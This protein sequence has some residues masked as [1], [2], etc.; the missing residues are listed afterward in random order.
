MQRLHPV[1]VEYTYHIGSRIDLEWDLPPLLDEEDLDEILEAL[2]SPPEY[3]ERIAPM[4]FYVGTEEVTGKNPSEAY[5]KFFRHYQRML[6]TIA[7][8]SRDACRNKFH[9]RGSTSFLGL[10]LCPE[11]I[12]RLIE[13]DYENADNTYSRIVSLVKSGDICPVVTAPFHIL[14]PSLENFEIRLL[15]RIGLTIYWPLLKAYHRA[16]FRKLQEEIF[17]VVFWLPEG[18]FSRNVL[19]IL[20]TEFSKKC[21]ES[22]IQERHLALL[23]DTEQVRE[24]ENDSLMKR[25]HAIRPTNS[26][27]DQVS[28]LFRDRAFTQWVTQGHPSVK[29]MLDR[30]IAKVD[31]SLRESGI[32]YLW[33]HMEPIESLVNTH[34]AA[35]NFQ[36]KLIKLTELGYQI[37]SPDTFVRRKLM[38]KY[39]HADNEPLRCAPL[40]NTGW[41]GWE[42]APTSLLRWEGIQRDYEGHPLH[43]D[44]DRPYRRRD[45]QSEPVEERGPQC[46]KPALWSTFRTCHKA[47]V[48]ECRTFLGGM[49]ELLRKIVPIERIPAQRRNVEDFL[50]RCSLIYWREH[51]IQTSSCSEADVQLI[52]FVQECLTKDCPEDAI[53]EEQACIAGVAA[54]AIFFSFEAQRSVTFSVEHIDHRATYEAVMLMTY[55]IIHAAQAFCWAD[56]RE[57]AEAL[58]QIMKRELFEF[59]S[60]Y[61]RYELS[62]LGVSLEDWKMSIVS[63]VEDSDLNVVARASRRIAARSLRRLGFGSYI[64]DPSDK[65]ISMAIGHLWSQEIDQPNLHWKNVVFCGLAEE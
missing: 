58:I 60:A 53:T 57:E 37:L 43:V 33:T 42:D 65:N 29:K 36:Q 35:M 64:V 40:D 15:V 16:V 1:Q 39:A 20:H 56:Q 26:T 27:R 38:K 52:E 46:W 47:V 23:L 13:F 22:G 55:A 14:L 25:W 49:L 31:A 61:Y 44:H 4:S 45:E 5:A 6:H 28:L 19:E 3:H 7:G 11:T 12:R 10:G 30:T 51:F 59:E 9:E 2:S 8:V 17:T 21:E 48:G 18:G 41:N 63:Q 34:K 24:R 62:S 32:D 50:T 54:R